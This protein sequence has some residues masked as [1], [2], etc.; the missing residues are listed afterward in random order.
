MPEASDMDAGSPKEMSVK[1]W[2]KAFAAAAAAAAAEDESEGDSECTWAISR[3]FGKTALRVACHGR[4]RS[5]SARL[6]A[7]A[8]RDTTSVLGY[9]HWTFPD[10]S[11]EDQ[12]PS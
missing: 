8:D 12:Y 2:V 5:F 4:G 11:V 7:A 1:K 6:A 10:Q 3:H 9:V